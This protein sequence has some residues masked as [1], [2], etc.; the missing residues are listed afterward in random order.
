MRIWRAA[1][2]EE[3]GVRL[4][5]AATRCDSVL[6]DSSAHSIDRDA[7]STSSHGLAGGQQ[8]KRDADFGDVARGEGAVPALDRNGA[9]SRHPFT[10]TH[11]LLKSTGGD[12]QLGRYR[13][14]RVLGQGAFGRVHLAF[15]EELERRVAIKVPAPDRFQ[16]PGDAERYLAEARIVAT[17]DHPNI[18]PVYDVGRTADGSVYVVSKFIEGPTLADRVEDRPAADEASR[19]VATV[20]RALDHAHRKRLIHR[21]VKPANILIE[22]ATG[23]PYVADFGLAI[24]EEAFAHEH[25][26][27]GTPA[28]MSPE[29][30]RG[31]GH[32]LDGRSDIFSL[33]VVFYELLTGKKPFRGST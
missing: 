32:R 16:N 3:N 5:E 19:L 13:L 6:S 4:P 2:S 11:S 8:E 23:T 10:E 18:V 14:L 22:D 9:E 28:Y 12:R 30:V 1:L 17:L 26:I 24:S 33:G 29:Q 7:D 25:N 21:D 20:A 15:D 27:A 31:E